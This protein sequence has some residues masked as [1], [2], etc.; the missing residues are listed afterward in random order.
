MVRW[1][2]SGLRAPRDATSAS[3]RADPRRPHLRSDLLLG[4]PNISTVGISPIA[5]MRKP[6]TATKLTYPFSTP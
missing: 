1:P 3:W 5:T 2:T 6:T 4:L